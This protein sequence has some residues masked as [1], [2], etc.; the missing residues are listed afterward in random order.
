MSLRLKTVTGVLAWTVLAAASAAHGQAGAETFT[1]TASVKTAGSTAASTPVT[2]VVD[3]KMPQA[4]ADKLV[5]AFKTGGAAALRKALVGVAP[6]G[7]IRL[8]GGKPTTTRLTIERPTDKG[9]LLTIVADTPIVFL[10]AGV[11]G[12]KPKEGYDFAVLDLEV[13][14]KGAGSGTLS[15]AAKVTVKQGVFVVDDYSGELVR[16]EGVTKG[17]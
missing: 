2:I 14:A 6:T 5:A 15:P 7:S 3:R 1:A 11:P 12:A 4:E 10:G 8:G 17:K 13:D 16:L 9:R